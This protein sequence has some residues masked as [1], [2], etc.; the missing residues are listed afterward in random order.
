MVAGR[1][2][3]LQANRQLQSLASP[4]AEASAGPTASTHQSNSAYCFLLPLAVP[5]FG[6]LTSLFWA[7][8]PFA[9]IPLPFLSDVWLL[10]FPPG[11][12]S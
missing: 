8:F 2:F 11:A 4:V 10:C 3:G 1:R 12:R 5:F 6:F 9:M 7:P